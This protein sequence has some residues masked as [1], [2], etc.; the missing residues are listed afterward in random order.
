MRHNKGAF[1]EDNSKV[2][3]NSDFDFDFSI[4]ESEEDRE[5]VVE[6]IKDMERPG[7]TG[8]KSRFSNGEAELRR[9]AEINVLIS[10]YSIKVAGRSQDLPVLWKYYGILDE[11]WES[12]RNIY[13]SHVNN[14]IDEV[15]L[16]CER[17]LS[18]CNRSS[19][20]DF[21]VHDKLLKFRGMLYRLKQLANLGFEVDRMGRG[22]FAR[23]RRK[24]IE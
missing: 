21:K 2:V 1:K 4:Y 13:G 18:A 12:I 9:L 17:L 24:V 20:I 19:K 23:T 3:D 16:E 14:E 8:L 7:V 11:F 22:T 6:S 15:K 10:K 5:E